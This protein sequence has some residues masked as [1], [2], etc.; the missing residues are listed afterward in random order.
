MSG[1]FDQLM[2]KLR[3][4]AQPDPTEV[5]EIDADPVLGAHFVERHWVLEDEDWAT[6]AERLRELFPRDT[7]PERPAEWYR[8]LAGT[9]WPG[10]LPPGN[11]P[12]Y[13]PRWVFGEEE[14]EH[15]VETLEGA[16]FEKQVAHVAYLPQNGEYLVHAMRVADD[17]LWTAD[18]IAYRVYLYPDLGGEAELR[19]WN[20]ERWQVPR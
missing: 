11:G 19:K 7:E 16:G 3:E 20:V 17:R 9:H 14:R 1:F 18:P 8:I 15:K 5:E 13:L 6:G 2:E 12:F 10:Q 4:A